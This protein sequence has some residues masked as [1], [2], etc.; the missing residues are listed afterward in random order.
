MRRVRIC[1]IALL[2]VSAHTP[3]LQATDRGAF[4]LK[5]FIGRTWRNESVRFPLM[6]AQLDDAR[7]GAPLVGPDDKAVPYQIV[8]GSDG[9]PPSL[10]FLADLNPF[11][12]RA[13][14]FADG[15]Q[16]QTPSS[17]IGIQET[18]SAILL[19]NS[20]IGIAIRKTLAAGQG[21]IEAIRLGSGQWVGGSSLAGAPPVASYSAELAARGPVFAEVVCRIRFAGGRT[22]QMAL[23]LQANEPVVL[24]SERSSVADAAEFQL[25]LSPGFSPR[26]LYYRF[27]KDSGSQGHE[28]KLS[29][30]TVPANFDGTAFV[31]EPWLHWWEHARQGTWFGIYNDERPDLLA[32]ATR[33]PGLWVDP[34]HTETRAAAQTKLTSARDGLTWTLPLAGGARQWMIE[35]LDKTASLAPLQGKNLYVAPLPQQYQIKYSDFPLDRINNYALQWHG[36]ETDHPRLIVTKEEVAGLCKGFQPD[37]ATLQVLRKAP[38]LPYQMDDRIKYLLCTDDREL[39]EH[40]AETAV[41]WMQSA[42]DM[43]VHQDRL[44]TLGFAPHQQTDIM[45]ALSLADLIWSTPYLSPAL[46]ER[47]KAQVAF[48]GYTVDRADYW[49]PER[50]FAANPN[51]TT[52]VAAYRAMLGAMIPSHP[53]AAAWLK[54]GMSELKRQLDQWSDANG[55]WREAPHYAMLSYDY[56]LAV[57]LM[58]H[59]AH[60]GDTLFDPKMK[61]VIEWF[62]KISTPPDAELDNHRHLPP[63]GNTYLR[64][65]SGEFG[66]VARLWKKADPAFAAQMQWMYEQQ[67]SSSEPG[68]GGFYPAFAGYRALL[69]DHSIAAKPPAYKSEL[70]PETGVMLRS[71]FSSARETQLYMIAGANHAHYDK[72]SGSLTLWGKGRIV[73]DDFGYEGEMPAADH[74]MVD[75]AALPGDAIMHV[76][77]FFAGEHLDYVA[78]SKRHNWR[79]RIAIVKDDDALGPNYF[80]IADTL[81]EQGSALWRL[82]LTANRVAIEGRTVVVT[83]PQDVD[84]DIYFARRGR[85]RLTT[86]QK[87]RQTYGMVRGQYGLAATTQTGLIGQVDSDAPVIA[88]IYPRLRT[89]A[90]PTFATIDGGKVIRIESA[91]GMDYVFLSSTPFSYTD[92]RVSFRGTVGAAQF[93]GGDIHLSLAAKG[94][95]SANGK[96]LNSDK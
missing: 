85:T 7:R 79:R 47:L 12:S 1:A 51:M 74:S 26:H 75:S 48:I 27:G 94:S 13:Y 49:S 63:I 70:F 96:T 42:V 55:G 61:K 33:S 40:L 25:Q 8:P 29:T 90:S 93:R 31:L 50:G 53:M 10:T 56:L 24:V 80:V 2:I 14:R 22:W 62:A 52:A 91:A 73:A 37:P 84:T 46:R 82:W 30:W 41:A 28:G 69:I 16:Q 81:K 44:V 17:N 78:A 9:T 92:K 4:R 20:R 3:S 57:F 95:I 38:V 34:Q 5:D 77:S 66:L 35:A 86:E 45:T 64:E 72:D 11:E 83:G 68:L 21:P 32:I 67:G 87:T 76:E 65:P 18:P 59:N 36:D 39:G 89:Q 15:H 23:R 88:V 6:A 43:L 19:T 58:A 54:D 71:H 60:F